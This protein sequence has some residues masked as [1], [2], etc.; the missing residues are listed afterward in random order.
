MRDDKGP[1]DDSLIQASMTRPAVA[2]TRET[3]RL[4]ALT[5]AEQAEA[6]HAAPPG[7]PTTITYTEELDE[8]RTLSIGPEVETV[9]GYTQAEWMADPMLGVKLLHPDDRERVGQLCNVANEALLP[10]HAEYR[11]IARDGRVVRI[12]DEARVV[13]G[14][15]GQPL[16]WEGR[17][18]VVD[19]PLTGRAAG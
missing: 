1:I 5:R 18:V 11:M 7:Q 14:A 2:L 13:Y 10:F 16:C 9:L 3:S 8:G 17:M 15:L 12:R 6:A 19:D 4:D